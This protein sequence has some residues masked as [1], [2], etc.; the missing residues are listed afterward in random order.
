MPHALRLRVPRC[1]VKGESCA[2]CLSSRCL[3]CSPPHF[4]L[5][6]DVPGV[7]QAP[8][9]APPHIAAAVPAGDIPRQLTLDT[10]QQLLV[11]HNLAVIAARYGVGNARAQRLIAAVR[12]NPR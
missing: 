2:L 9:T 8:H 1:C 12:P 4:L 7:G 6:V 5:W 10:A 11:Q 3:S